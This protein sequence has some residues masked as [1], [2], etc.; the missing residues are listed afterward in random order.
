MRRLKTL[1]RPPIYP[2]TPG[3]LPCSSLTHPL[4]LSS[5]RPSVSFG[6]FGFTEHG[7][8]N[9]SFFDKDGSPRISLGLFKSNWTG[10]AYMDE[11]EDIR[12]MLGLGEG[13]LPLLSLLDKDGEM[14]ASIVLGDDGVAAAIFFDSYQKIRLGVGV[15]KDGLPDMVFFDQDGKRLGGTT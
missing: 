4:P 2:K 9:L 1:R 10:V 6:G 8:P 3:H 5:R 12:S 7:S 11:D 13:I 14:R 15:R